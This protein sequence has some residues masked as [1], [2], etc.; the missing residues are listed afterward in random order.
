MVHILTENVPC[1][2][3]IFDSVALYGHKCQ[4][5]KS[6]FC[7]LGGGVEQFWLYTVTDPVPG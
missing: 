6:M 2:A 4:M 5:L 7:T 3:T 1:E